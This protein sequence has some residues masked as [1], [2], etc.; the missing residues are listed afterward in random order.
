MATKSGNMDEYAN[1]ELVRRKNLFYPPFSR[2][3]LIRSRSE[4]E[5]RAEEV[6][7]VFKNAL[8]NLMRSEVLGPV[9]SPIEKIKKEFRYQLFIKTTEM[10]KVRNILKNLIPDVYR[11][12]HKVRV[13]IDV[14]PLNM[15]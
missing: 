6:L 2:I 11:L 13:S 9:K 4:D 1:I 7:R 5:K 3:I 10:N 14:D 15:L 12:H 8:N